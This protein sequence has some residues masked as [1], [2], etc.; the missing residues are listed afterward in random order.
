MFVA[1][2]S[3]RWNVP[4]SEIEV[5]AGVVSHAR[6]GQ[7]A[8]FGELANEAIR[9]PVPAKVTLKD[10][11]DFK[12]I[13]T[14]VPRLDSAMKTDGSAIFAL[15]VRLPGKLT[16]VIR[17][18]PQFGATV[19]SFDAES[20]RKVDGVVE[21]VQV[22]QGVAVIAKDTW[23]ALRGR[24]ALRVEWDASKA[25]TRSSE[26]IFEEYKKLAGQRGV[27]AL[28]RGDAGK[29]IERAAKTLDAEFAFPY[30]AHAPMEMMNGTIEARDG[31]AEA[32]MGSQL[33]TVDAIAI[34]RELGLKDP[35]AVKINTLLGGGSFGRRGN[36]LGDWSGEFGAVAKAAG[37]TQPIHVVW[38]REDDIRGGFYRPMAYHKVKAGIDASGKLAGWRHTTVSQSIFSGTPFS[39][40]MVK[41][42]L[43]ASAVEGIVDNAYAIA[44]LDVDAHMAVSPV[45]VLWYRSVGHSHTAHVM[46]TVVD[47]LAHLAGKDPVEFRLDLL[48]RQSRDAQTLALAAQKAGWGKALPKRAGR[49]VAY[50]RSFG[51]CV[52]M[53]AEV[54]VD[55]GVIKVERIVAAVDVGIAVNP[56]VVSAQV[57]GANALR[58]RVTLKNGVPQQSNFHDY[59]VTRMREMPRVEVHIVKSS[60]RPSGIGEP[61]VPPVAPSI[62]NAV[63]A[64][65]GKRLRSLPFDLSTLG[66]P[67][68]LE[69][70]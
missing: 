59:Q 58:N 56:D 16:C 14:H 25:E 33:Q 1:A 13:G 52:A 7:R 42:G 41:D 8:R 51:S 65:T 6:S 20:A 49:G 27:S 5:N 35:S 67:N 26:E 63:F 53:I 10:P 38:T 31:G 60:L 69:K 61:G 36:P 64:A 15:D 23:S 17:R 55:A 62:G 18:A 43:D 12:L 3:K 68:A 70:A 30:L 37:R 32:W 54:T 45:P 57:E 24:E 2:A 39:A 28:R 29:A 44:D 22:P 11:K 9:Q 50:H 46:E 47:E 48:G 66:N 40:M 34:A 21:V 4:A 19:K